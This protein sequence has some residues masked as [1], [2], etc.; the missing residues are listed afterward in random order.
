MLSALYW[1]RQNQPE[2]ALEIIQ[3]IADLQPDENIWKIEMGTI[4]AQTGDLEGAMKYFLDAI[5]AEP[6]NPVWS[7]ELI[8]FCLQN[9]YEVRST[10]LPAAREYLKLDKESAQSL[11]MMGW[12]MLDLKNSL[13]AERYLIR[14]LEIDPTNAA[15]H[16]HL[17]QVYLLDARPRQAYHHL[18][19]AYSLASRQ[20]D[21]SVMAERLLE[22]YFPAGAPTQP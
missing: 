22:K 14:A 3:T 10:A 8:T 5:A 11:D 2:R 12:V 9:N 4:T 16:L 18:S 20:S 1:R 15:A 17:G 6:D 13:N 7:K 19:T 21:T